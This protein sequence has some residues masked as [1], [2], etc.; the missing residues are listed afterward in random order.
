MIRMVGFA[1]TCH[2]ARYCCFTPGRNHLAWRWKLI[3]NFTCIFY[4]RKAPASGCCTG[5][6]CS[7]VQCCRYPVGW[8]RTCR[9]RSDDRQHWRCSAEEAV[10]EVLQI[11]TSCA[12]ASHLARLESLERN[13]ANDDLDD[14]DDDDGSEEQNRVIAFLFS[15]VEFSVIVLPRTW[16]NA[17]EKGNR[18]A[19]K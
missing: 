14:D 19:Y 6:C 2:R 13:L 3:R 4:P 18:C 12:A 17:V 9:F 5:T 11:H 15:G 10:V 1:A 8:I 7:C 16:A